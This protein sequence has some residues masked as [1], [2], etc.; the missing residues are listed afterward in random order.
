M[1]IIVSLTRTILFPLF[2]RRCEII[3]IVAGAHLRSNSFAIVH[4]RSSSF[5]IVPYRSCS[6][7][8][9]PKVCQLVFLFF[10]LECLVFNVSDTNVTRWIRRT[11]RG[12][13]LMTVL[14]GAVDPIT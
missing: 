2:L 10:P 9:V 13:E 12:R 5:A 14:V 8:L 3:T 1:A 4:L 6:S 7:S 11:W